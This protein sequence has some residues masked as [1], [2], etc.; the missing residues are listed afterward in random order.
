MG[1]YILSSSASILW[2]MIWIVKLDVMHYM[3]KTTQNGVWV[4]WTGGER[5]SRRM[6][7]QKSSLPSW[8][9]VIIVV[10]FVIWLVYFLF[11]A[12]G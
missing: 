12:G 11:F 6:S 3:Y 5:E 4:H 8:V 7:E 1:D 9:W 10:V 2:G